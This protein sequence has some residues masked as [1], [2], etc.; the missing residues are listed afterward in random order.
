MNQKA[1]IN[2][3]FRELGDAYKKKYPAITLQDKKVIRAIQICRT[4]DNGGRI[5]QCDACGYT[6]TLYNSCRNRHCPQCQN[7][8]KEKWIL[9]RKKDILP[10]TYFH[11]VFTL[12]DLLNP[13]VFRNKKQIFN[14]LFNASKKTLLSVSKEEKY[15]GADIGFFSIL[16]TW[17]Q[18]LNLHP[19]IHCVV[20]GGGF[21]TTK[22]KW[23]HSRQNYIVPVQVLKKR[24]RSLFLIELKNLYLNNSLNLSGS[25]F[26][27]PYSFQALINSLFT[28]EW[29]VY[30]KE[31]FGNKE[32]VIEYLGRYT[33]KI[34]I[35]NNRIIS[36]DNGI[37]RFKY[38]D[39][40]DHNKQK[41]AQM[42]SLTF[43][44]RFMI[45]VLPHRFVRIRYYGILAH[46]NKKK[47][48]E[49]CREFYNI[50]IK[51]VVNDLSWENIYYLKTGKYASQCPVCK[52][53]K[54]LLKEILSPIRY[55]APP[56]GLLLI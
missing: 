13:I 5:Q 48:I 4:E 26:E 44:R 2:I 27:N 22:G 32:S 35:T 51:H 17:G 10:F 53:G 30:M 24:F 37:V 41:T 18:K 52:K 31:S 45:H 42:N 16:H 40:K 50:T 38:R 36:I 1:T 28:T 20:P 19:H 46:R 39:Y 43:M 15:F 8:K 14:L 3:L 33:H 11:A 47:A 7:M 29:V 54:F 49:A 55:R 21:S 23:I 56:D 6:V 25:K 9:D 34:A 12:P